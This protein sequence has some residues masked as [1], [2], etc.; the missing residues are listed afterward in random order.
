MTMHRNLNRVLLAAAIASFAGCQTEQTEPRNSR[1][2][3]ADTN[4]D[5]KLSRA[6]ATDYFVVELFESTDKN[7]D[8]KVTWEEWNVPGANVSKA[9]FTSRDTNKDGAVS[10]DEALVA[11]RKDSVFAKAFVATDTNKDGYVTKPE[12][13]AYY[14]SKEGPPN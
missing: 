8:G 12:A 3:K 10:M 13:K 11:G 1:F 9:K 4:K 6:E 2:D 7:H 14:A 5:G